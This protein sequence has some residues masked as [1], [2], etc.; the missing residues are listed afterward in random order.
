MTFDRQLEDRD[1]FCQNILKQAVVF[2][3]TR[4][5]VFTPGKLGRVVGSDSASETS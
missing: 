4:V 3:E 5:Y 2:K 1:C